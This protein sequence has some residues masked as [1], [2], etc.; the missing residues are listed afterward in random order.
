MTT[1]LTILFL[2]NAGPG[3]GGGH[4]LRCLSLARAL[5]ERGTRCVFATPSAGVELVNRF[6]EELF[7]ARAVHDG[8]GAA[9]VCA[10]LSP[11]AVVVDHYGLG[12]EAERAFAAPGRVLMA[13]DD[14]ADRP[15]AVD[16]LLDPGY[17]RRPSDY[18]G[19]L[20]ANAHLL[21]GPDYALLRPEFRAKRVEVDRITRRSRRPATR[22]SIR[23]VLVSFG[24][25][26]IDGVAARAVR[27]VRTASP[28]VNIVVMLS[29][30]AVS[31]S[32]LEAE[33]VRD[34]LLSLCIE[35]TRPANLIAGADIG[36]GAGG[37][38]VWERFCLGLPS[39]AVIVA[40]NQ[41]RLIEQLDDEQLLLGCD[42]TH[43]DF[44]AEFLARYAYLQDWIF[45]EGLRQR[46]RELCDGR[47]AER[48]AEALLSVLGEK[49]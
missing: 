14:L 38:M 4:V 37:S 17:G 36:I 27:L 23:T 5:R 6:G 12:A 40:E 30:G 45:R 2:P 15:H 13:L 16:L 42:L 11:D 34:P 8:A 28:D 18:A 39:L 19:K 9:E 48:A 22:P 26:D 7:E 29:A 46:S 25:S 44:E 24:L 49:R 32:E 43:R 1:P 10:A 21:L 3:V 31:R 20:V 35:E 47:G 41:R 33:S